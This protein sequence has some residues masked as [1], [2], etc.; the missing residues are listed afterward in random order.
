[1]TVGGKQL[2]VALEISVEGN[3]SKTLG[4]EETGD[5]YTNRNSYTTSKYK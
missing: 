3:N 2:P 5:Y 1:M 4:I